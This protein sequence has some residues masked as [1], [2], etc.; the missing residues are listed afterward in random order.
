LKTQD[1]IPATAK[2]FITN[3]I[4]HK[5]GQLKDTP[6][7]DRVLIEWVGEKYLK[8]MKQIMSYMF[9]A[10]MPI[11]RIFCLIGEGL[12]GKG[13][14]LRLI[15]NFVGDEN[16]CATEIEI[17]V[18]N[19]FESSKL[20]RKLVCITGEIDKG[21]FTKTK[22]LKS[23]SGDDLIRFEFKGKDG[24]DSHNYAK[25]LIAT[26]HLPETTDKSSGFYRR[27]LIVDFPNTFNEKKNILD[28][29]PEEEYQNF[30]LASIDILNELLSSG[31]FENEGSI[32]ER[33]SN[34][35]H[36]AGFIKPF[37]KDYCDINPEYAHEFDDFC[38]KFNDFIMSEGG[39]K[40]SKV[41]IGRIIRNCGYEMK[42]KKI[43]MEHGGTTTRMHVFGIKIKFQDE[44]V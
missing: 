18:N 14:F 1:R 41:E 44:V 13:T 40:K 28:E 34:Y 3:P 17:L 23:L 11:H 39:K 36:H 9:L 8:T 2:Y 21:I 26:N 6:N 42:V 10:D 32:Q 22:T 27:W 20:Y 15:E 4:P 31:N 16:K 38:Y 33:Q 5:L 29:I 25:P 19:R 12:N 7:I 30:C 43:P 24:F 37:I 35:E